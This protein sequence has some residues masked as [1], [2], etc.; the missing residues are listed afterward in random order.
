MWKAAFPQAMR[1]VQ[2]QILAEKIRGEWGPVLEQ[3]AD[4]TLTAMGA[5]WRSMLAKGKAEADLRDSFRS[6]LE[7]A[8]K[9]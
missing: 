3:E 7:E 5:C 1:Q 9:A 4:A 8:A 2:V 6:I